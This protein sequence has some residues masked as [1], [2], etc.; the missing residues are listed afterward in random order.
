MTS[1]GGPP[2]SSGS[3]QI[4]RALTFPVGRY[5]PRTG[6]TTLQRMSANDPMIASMTAINAPAPTPAP[7]HADQPEL[8]V[9][10]VSIGGSCTSL[11]LARPKSCLSGEAGEPTLEVCSRSD[12]SI[13]S[14]DRWSSPTTDVGVALRATSLVSGD[15][16]S[17]A[18]RAAGTITI[19]TVS[20]HVTAPVL[21]KM[22]VRTEVRL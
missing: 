8:T 22:R 17:S 5:V 12:A 13:V 10:T 6:L 18:A 4:G 16:K 20:T 1:D 21:N 11:T 7:A 19:K 15:R 3:S 2:D 9:L 14:G